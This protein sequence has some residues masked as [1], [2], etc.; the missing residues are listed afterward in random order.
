MPESNSSRWRSWHY[1]LLWLIAISSLIFNILLLAGLYNFRMRAQREVAEVNQILE[2]VEI[3]ENFELPVVV[4]E[5]L[6]I[7]ITVPF[8]DNFEVPINAVVPVEMMIPINENISFPINEVVSI[9][10]DVTVSVNI[11]GIPIP[12]DIPIRAD[13][14]ISLNVD[15]PIEMEVPVSTEIPIDLMIEVP[16]DTAVP[17]QAE[18][19]V[20]LDFP[21]TVPLDELGFNQ[22]LEQVKDGLRLLGEVLGAPPAE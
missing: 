16:I 8:T 2:S 4:D 13:I 22:L 15:V 11:A 14:P 18:V 1:I 7:S 10:R 20:Q 3:A 19:P 9:N 17:I 6:A 5:T 12:V 21:V